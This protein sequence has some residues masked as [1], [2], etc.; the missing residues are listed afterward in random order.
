MTR[1]V[2]ALT[3][4]RVYRELLDGPC[5]DVIRYPGA[6][7]DLLDHD[8]LSLTATAILQPRSIFANGMLDD[9]ERFAAAPTTADGFVSTEYHE[10][11]PPRSTPIST[12][13]ASARDPSLDS[14]WHGCRRD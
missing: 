10:P 5:L 7:H 12:Q 8:G 6:D 14:S 9:I 2:L 3:T 1:S 4:E 13:A 11:C